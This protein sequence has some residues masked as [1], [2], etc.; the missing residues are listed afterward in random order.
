ML[1]LRNL[2]RCPAGG[3]SAFGG[4]I[5]AVNVP[6]SR[7]ASSMSGREMPPERKSPGIQVANIENPEML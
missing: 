3:F 4:R 1:N 6:G 7:I 5:G 2:W